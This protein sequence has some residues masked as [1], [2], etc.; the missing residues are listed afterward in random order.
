MQDRGYTIVDNDVT[1]L[2][3]REVE[4]MVYAVILSCESM[5]KNAEDYAVIQRRL[6]YILTTRFFKKVQCLHIVLTRD[7]M[8]RNAQKELL[9]QFEN[10]WLVAEDTGQVYIFERQIT[11]FDDIRR[12]LENTLQDFQRERKKERVHYITPVNAGIVALNIICFFLVIIINQD[13]LAVYDADIMLSMGAQSYGTVMGG[14]WYQI[15]TSLFL[16]FGMSHLVNN[17][18]LLCYTGY[19]LEKRIGSISYFFVYFASGMIGN[20]ASLVYY[21]GQGEQVVSA[22]ASGSICGVIGALLVILV[23]RQIRTPNLSPTRI[24][25]MIALTIYHGITSTGVDNA[26]HIGGLVAGI[27]GGF[28]LSKI[29]RYDKLEEV[30]FMR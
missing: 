22:G 4:D 14:A 30:N 9:E 25:I 7:G 15:I 1:T 2:W 5:K 13:I 19:E 17:M 16:H 27:L 12:G 23:I 10:V 29:S 11:D 20:I 3:Y 28:L 24:F 8:F 18:L 21:H 6:E 26:A